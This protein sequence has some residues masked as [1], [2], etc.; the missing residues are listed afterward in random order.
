MNYIGLLTQEEKAVLCEIIT[1]REFKELFKRNEQAFSKIRKGFRAKSLSDQLALSLAISNIDRPFIADWV[2]YRVDSWLKEIQDNISVL[3]EKGLQ[4]NEA[5]ATTMLDSYFAKHVDIYLKISEHEADEATIADITNCMDRIRSVRAQTSEAMDRVRELEEENQKLRDDIASALQQINTVQDENAKKNRELEQEKSTL[6]SLLDDAQARILELEAPH[7]ATEDKDTDYLAQF[8]DTNPSILPSVSSEEFVSLCG[9]ISDYNGQ[10][11]LIRHADL[12]YNG[13][14]QIF[15]KNE[16]L[17][18]F[19]ANRDKIFFKDGPSNVDFFGIWNWSAI[20]NDKDSSKD[21]VRSKYNT[22][23]DAIEVL[24]Y[25]EVADLDALISILKNGID[26]HPHSRKTMFSFRA[27][28]GQF[29]GILCSAN[30]LNYSN[31]KTTFSDNCNV[32]PVYDFSGDDL[33]RLDNGLSFFK[34]AFVGIPS[35]LYQLKTSLE[36]VKEIVFSALSWTTYKARGF[37]R[38]EYRTFK[39]FLGSIPVDDITKKIENACHCS[40]SSAKELLD[41]F[42]SEAW[43]Y[44]DGS[45]LEDAVILSAIGAHPELQEKTKTLLREDWECENKTLL[46]NAQKNL[47]IVE[48]KVIA[49]DTKLSEIR[50][51]FAK[52]KSEEER[53]SAFIAEKQKLAEDVE[54]AVANR[55]QQARKNAA[56]FIASMA[57]VSGQAS[58]DSS[59]HVPGEVDSFVASSAVATYCNYGV[60]DLS[61]LEAHHTWKDVIDTV[62]FEV[63]EAGVSKKYSAGLA[64]FLCSAYIE[65]QPIL[66]VGPNA[67]DISQAFSASIAGHRRGE[68]CCEGN[69]S[70][71]VIEEIGTNGEDIVII[72]NLLTSGWMNR[73]PE[74]IS[75]KDVFYIATHPY[76]EDIQ[77]EPKSL[78]NFMLPLFTEFFVDHPAAKEYCGGYFADDFKSYSASKGSPR[79]LKALSAISLSPLVKARISSLVAT[80]HGIRSGSTSDEEFLFAVLPISFASMVISELKEALANPQKGISISAELKRSL[81]YIFGDD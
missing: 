42:L 43:K 3:E 67:I 23:L 20:P 57:F 76:T 79:E 17:L 74:I 53:L 15:R 13:H 41:A 44:V 73:V 49:T 35:R 78:Y 72:N 27:S 14:Y 60:G 56:E 51:A 16:D 30:D 36:I 75:K 10:P 80:M 45:S 61:E 66:L 7:T 9:V 63:E 33:L 39:D 48:D 38:A 19:F 62:A 71:R 46:E 4:H 37:V 26:Y 12:S 69:Y 21:Y 40:P 32:V 54:T 64:A 34:N 68:L 24:I 70:N 50:E 8:D 28:K 29:C 81:Q 52:T 55:I 6:E 18:P 59:A 25:S 5:L 22:A 77:V 2:N 31:G 47:K 11:W 65:K 1:G 58:R